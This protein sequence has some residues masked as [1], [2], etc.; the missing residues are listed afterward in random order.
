MGAP[1][2]SLKATVDVLND[3]SEV[4]SLVGGN[5]ADWYFGALDDVGTA[6]VT[7]EILDVL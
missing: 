3:A 2:V 4:D 5:G 6:L 7:G 1:A